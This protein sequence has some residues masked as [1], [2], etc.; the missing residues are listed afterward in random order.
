MGLITQETVHLAGLS[1]HWGGEDGNVRVEQNSAEEIHFT[2]IAGERLDS[3]LVVSYASALMW[4]SGISGGNFTGQEPA[5]IQTDYEYRHLISQAKFPVLGILFAILLGN[6]LVFDSYR[7]KEAHVSSQIELNSGIISKR[8]SLES[9]LKAKEKYLGYVGENITWYSMELDQIA[10]T[11][12]AAI[13]LD[14]LEV[15]PLT[16]KISKNEQILFDKKLVIR[17]QATNSLTMNEWSHSLS[18][19]SWVKLVS[20]LNFTRNAETGQ[21]NFI[22][23]VEVKE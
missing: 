21:G 1:L 3:R 18:S 4:L 14:R 11:V 20:I 6:F 2:D 8:D 10:S 16:E 12:P 15:N 17:G 19:L 7:K 9:I 5:S 23:E 13:T 22:L